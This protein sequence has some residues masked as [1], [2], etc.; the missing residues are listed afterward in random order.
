M[1]LFQ[2][3]IITAAFW[4]KDEVFE[5]D[6]PIHEVR[7]GEKRGGKERGKREGGKGGGEKR[8]EKGRGGKE[9]EG[10]VHFLFQ[11]YF[12]FL[13]LVFISFF[14]LFLLIFRRN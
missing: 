1:I 4:E 12:L 7:E 3:R 5:R 9:G 2:Q 10:R 13:T 6:N 14:P 11:F 8:G